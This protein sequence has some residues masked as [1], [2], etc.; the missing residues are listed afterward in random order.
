MQ[1]LGIEWRRDESRSIE[2]PAVS[3]NS[4]GAWA[5]GF[6]SCNSGSAAC[7][8]VMI[9]S[10]LGVPA[11]WS[12]VSFL[13][14]TMAALP[15]HLYR[16]TSGRDERVNGGLATLIHDAPNPEW[17]SFDWREYLFRSEE[18][19]SELQSLMRSSYAVFCLKKKTILTLHV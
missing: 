6:H 12:A 13:S 17:T 8:N 3:L 11:V 2:R 19:T 5:S 18:H 10:A 4:A 14:R 1:L 16:V 7:V 9:E 15:L